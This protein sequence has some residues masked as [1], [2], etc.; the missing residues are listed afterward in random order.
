MPGRSVGT[1]E[2]LARLTER[3][4]VGVIGALAVLWAPCAVQPLLD[5][6]WWLPSGTI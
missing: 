5:G 1:A 3:R 2:V 4:R 6:G